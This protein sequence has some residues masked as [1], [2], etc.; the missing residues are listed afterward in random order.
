MRSSTLGIS[1]TPHL[2]ACEP[3]EGTTSR[4]WEGEGRYS[5]SEFTR[6]GRIQV[7]CG[8]ACVTVLESLAEK[9]PVEQPALQATLAMRGAVREP[10]PSKQ[11]R[12][13]CGCF[14]SQS[15]PAE[16]RIPW[17]HCM[18]DIKMNRGQRSNQAG[19]FHHVLKTRQQCHTTKTEYGGKGIPNSKVGDRSRCPSKRRR[20][21]GTRRRARK[22]IISPTAAVRV[23]FRTAHEREPAAIFF[24][25]LTVEIWDYR[26]AT[27]QVERM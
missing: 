10:K 12:Y 25:L 18:M 16:M 7:T 23:L 8:A 20:S 17:G 21:F 4:L 14:S 5:G 3:G 19:V 2:I 6:I 13:A 11:N 26:E 22:A 24:S 27:Y 9:E 1:F 15:G